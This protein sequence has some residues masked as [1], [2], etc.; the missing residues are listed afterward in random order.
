MILSKD[1][2]IWCFMAF[3]PID[4]F[5]REGLAVKLLLLMEIKPKQ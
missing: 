3:V 1:F 5:W 4:I 2:D